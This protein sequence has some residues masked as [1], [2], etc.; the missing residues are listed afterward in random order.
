MFKSGD[1]IKFS[2]TKR[3]LKDFENTNFTKD[4]IYKI[5]RLSEQFE[6]QILYVLNDHGKE[7]WHYTKLFKLA[8]K[9]R[10]HK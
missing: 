10:F 5:I 9:E 8:K 7:D 4:K 3:E 1:K 2:P 6:E